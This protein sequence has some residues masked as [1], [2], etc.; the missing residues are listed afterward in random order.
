MKIPQVY[1][2]LLCTENLAREIDR[3]LEEIRQRQV[4]KG[5]LPGFSIADRIRYVKGTVSMKREYNPLSMRKPR[6]S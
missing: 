2:R 5:S 4:A 1:S 6:K 3:V